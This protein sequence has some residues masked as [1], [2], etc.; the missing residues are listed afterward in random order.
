AGRRGGLDALVPKPR[1]D[2]GCSKISPEVQQAILSAKQDN[3]RRS[4]RQV[5]RL[6][7][8]TGTVARKSLSRSAVH[9]LLQRNGL[10]QQPAHQ[11]EEKRSFAAEFAGSIWYGDVMHGPRV[12]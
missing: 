6:L 12:A 5:V 8:A 11:P 3:P 7:E 9:R 1:A 2:R 4:V 10:S